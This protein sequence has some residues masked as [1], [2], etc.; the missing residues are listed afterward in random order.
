MRTITAVSCLILAFLLPGY[1][2]QDQSQSDQKVKEYVKVVN[3][4]LLLRVMEDG[5][6]RGGLK[7]DDFRLFEDGRERPI[8]GFFEL[9]RRMGRPLDLTVE[10][11][12]PG[13]L[14]LLFFWLN[15]LQEDIRVQ[16]DYFFENI[17]QP[18]DRV[19]LS[20]TSRG[21]EIWDPQKK[22]EVLESF[23]E[24]W[25]EVSASYHKELVGIKNELASLVR[26]AVDVVQMARRMSVEDADKFLNT[27][28]NSFSARYLA[29]S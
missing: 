11:P 12:R 17:Y 9:S 4:Q 28:R 10:S 18:G 2:D 13:R 25:Q 6:T 16:L 14:F 8:N 29:D 20:S 21:F 23:Y 3:V 26:E 5:R 1:S 7:K 15:Q 27:S 24:H 19:V 22:K